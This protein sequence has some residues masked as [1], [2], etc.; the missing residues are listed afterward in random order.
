MRTR[1]KTISPFVYDNLQ[2]RILSFHQNDADRRR[3]C[4]C[5]GIIRYVTHHFKEMSDLE[6]ELKAVTLEE[7]KDE[8]EQN[9]YLD[10]GDG[11]VIKNKGMLTKLELL[12]SKL[13]KSA[14]ALQASTP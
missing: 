3:N 13:E 8:A 12:I 14:I 2:Q 4:T 7:M 9:E 5:E 11:V 1:E 6:L 10:E